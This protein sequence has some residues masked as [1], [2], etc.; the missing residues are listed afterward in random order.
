MRI[1]GRDYYG[2][3]CADGVVGVEGELLARSGFFVRYFEDQQGK[4]IEPIEVPA[5]ADGP[6]ITTR[7]L[8][9]A[10]QHYGK[11]A[12]R[13]IL[14]I[15]PVAKLLECK[16]TCDF[17][18]GEVVKRLAGKS[19]REMRAALAEAKVPLPSSAHWAARE[20]AECVE[21]AYGDPINVGSWLTNVG[22]FIYDA[23]Q[24]PV[25]LREY[26]EFQVGCPYIVK[27]KMARCLPGPIGVEAGSEAGASRVMDEYATSYKANRLEPDNLNQTFIAPSVERVVKKFINLVKTNAADEAKAGDLLKEYVVKLIEVDS[28]IQEWLASFRKNMVAGLK[29]RGKNRA[30]KDQLGRKMAEQIARIVSEFDSTVKR[31]ISE[32]FA[33]IDGVKETTANANAIRVGLVADAVMRAWREAQRESRAPSDAF[34]RAKQRILTELVN[35]THANRFSAQQFARRLETAKK[36]NKNVAGLVS[37]IAVCPHAKMISQLR[38]WQ[39]WRAKAIVRLLHAA[40]KNSKAPPV[41]TGILAAAAALLKVEGPS[42]ESSWDKVHASIIIAPWVLGHNSNGIQVMESIIAMASVRYS[43]NNEVASLIRG[44]SD[45]IAK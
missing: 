31:E 17:M 43:G 34:Q 21:Q 28:E 16:E 18:V 9:E 23:Q 15:L 26:H 39:T 38:H 12:L 32:H 10:L 4:V 22:S 36:I 13:E 20:F 14:S 42:Q 7:I 19:F 27:A 1:N 8:T 2:V 45:I 44:V 6:Q 37:W 25:T 3:K 33:N 29:P 11:P 30:D 40:R 41:E 5:T 35:I 24:P